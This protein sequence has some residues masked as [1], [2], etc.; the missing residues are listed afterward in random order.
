MKTRTLS[1][2]CG[3]V[4]CLLVGAVILHSLYSHPVWALEDC[5]DNSLDCLRKKAEEY[6]TKISELQGN[7]KTLSQA[8]AYLNN[9]IALAQ[10][11]IKRTEVEITALEVQI[12]NLNGRIN[13]LEISL[14]QLT[15][16]LIGRIQENYKLQKQDPFLL[17]LASDGLNDLLRKYKYLQV[18][19]SYTQQIITQAETQKVVYTQEKEEKEKKQIEVEKLR[20]KL[21]AQRASLQDQQRQKQSLLVL[22]KNDE[23]KYQSLLAQAEA[24]IAA[25]SRFVVSQ[26]GASLLSNQTK[27]DGWG[28][29]YNQRDTQWGTFSIGNSREPMNLY[30]CLVTSM[31][32]VASH[33]GKNLNPGMIA[34]S[35]SPFAGNTALMIQ[36]SW[37]VNGV[38]TTRT[39]VSFSLSKLDEEIGAGRPVVIGLFSSSFP[40]HFIVIKG[41]DNRGYIMNDPFLQNGGDRPLTDRYTTADMKTLDIVRVQ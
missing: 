2:L 35:T 15:T 18:T 26:G 13:S 40:G 6:R 14:Q 19:Q 5:P 41:K 25:F 20:K 28:C 24:Q 1:F 3:I 32:M 21:E 17:L 33:Y 31:A 7:Q 38:T 8:I 22:T 16:I 10:T 37:S 29:Y 27:C 39:R 34:Q 23:K 36:G 11:E 4:L 12:K 9:K 30:G